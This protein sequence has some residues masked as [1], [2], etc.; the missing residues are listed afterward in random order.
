MRCWPGRPSTDPLTGLLNHGAIVAQADM[1][2][3]E[4]LAVD[5][6][7]S[8]LFFDIDRFKQINDTYGHQAGDAILADTASRVAGGLRHNDQFGRYG[9]EEFLVVLPHTDQTE[10]VALAERLREVVADQAVRF[11]GWHGRPRD[12]QRRGGD[13]RCDAHH[14]RQAVANRRSRPVSGEGRGA[15]PGL[16]LV[17]GGVRRAA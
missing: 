1:A 11:A 4:A 14:P 15:G 10:A 16:Q 13:G 9:G 3:H 6:G 12:D 7:M 2:L 8:L 5:E 17:G